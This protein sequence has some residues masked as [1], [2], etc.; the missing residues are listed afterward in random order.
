MGPGMAGL[1]IEDTVTHFRSVWRS[2]WLAVLST[3]SIIPWAC[4]Q[5]SLC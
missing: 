4:C 1:A 3:L 2:R 5:P